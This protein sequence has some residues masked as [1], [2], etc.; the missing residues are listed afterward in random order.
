[1]T[2]EQVEP[3]YLI[4]YKAMTTYFEERKM[5]IVDHA[6]QGADSML[7]AVNSLLPT[8]KKRGYQ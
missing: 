7:A 5:E 8:D 4:I 6:E 2:T 1:M 3:P